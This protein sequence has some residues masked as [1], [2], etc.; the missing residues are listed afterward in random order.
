MRIHRAIHNR[1]PLIETTLATSTADIQ[2]KRMTQTPLPCTQPMSPG[3]IPLVLAPLE[4]CAWCWPHLYPGQPYPAHW[5]STICP[6]HDA[7]F[8]QQRAIRRAR[9]LVQQEGL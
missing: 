7:W 9:R 3:E 2:L 8:D 6:E 4:G 1:P 5:S